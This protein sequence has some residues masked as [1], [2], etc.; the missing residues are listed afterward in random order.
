MYAAASSKRADERM[1]ERRIRALR[2]LRQSLAHNLP[3]LPGYDRRDAL[4][5]VELINFFDSNR[6]NKS[7]DALAVSTL[8]NARLRPSPGDDPAGKSVRSWLAGADIHLY[9]Q[10]QIRHV[11]EE[12]YEEPPA[13]PPSGWLDRLQNEGSSR[14]SS[15]RDPDPESTESKPMPLPSSIADADTLFFHEL[16]NHSWAV[17][18]GLGGTYIQTPAGA[19]WLNQPMERH[20]G[21][22]WFRLDWDLSTPVSDWYRPWLMG[23]FLSALNSSLWAVAVGI[24]ASF[25]NQE[26]WMVLAVHYTYLNGLVVGGMYVFGCLLPICRHHLRSLMHHRKL[27][28]PCIHAAGRLELAA[29][30]GLVLALDWIAY[31]PSLVGTKNP[32][33]TLPGHLAGLNVTVAFRL[34]AVTLTCGIELIAAVVHAGVASVTH[35]HPRFLFEFT[36]WRWERKMLKVW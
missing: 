13:A 33:T 15:D 1:T 2:V 12:A 32:S 3:W 10:G 5:V 21:S 28:M 20:A 26:N 29:L 14:R 8:V 6:S 34:L 22:E 9:A 24:R 17:L 16:E 25:P 11:M 4:T 36:A 23:G 7:L 18:R 19:F 35:R 30:L 27:S 31:A